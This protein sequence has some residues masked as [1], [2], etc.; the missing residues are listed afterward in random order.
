MGVNFNNDNNN[1][2]NRKEFENNLARKST[3]M[4]KNERDK[5]MSIF[6]A[7]AGDDKIF[8]ADEAKQVFAELQALDIDKNKSISKEELNN[9][10]NE[11]EL[12]KAMS[13][14]DDEKTRDS[15]FTRIIEFVKTLKTEEPTQKDTEKPNTATEK[16]AQHETIAEERGYKETAIS[17]DRKIFYDEQNK[18]YVRWSDKNKNFIKLNGMTDINE[19]GVMTFNGIRCRYND[20]GKLEKVNDANGQIGEFKQGGTGDC[21]L[22]SAV[23]ALNNNDAGKEMLKDIVKADGNGNVTVS[24]KG[25]NKTYTISADELDSKDFGEKSY[26]KGDRDVL[27]IEVAV[28]KFRTEILEMKNKGQ[29]VSQYS[30]FFSSAMNTEDVLDGGDPI[31]AIQ[32]LT[33]KS[34]SLVTSGADNFEEIKNKLPEFLTPQNPTSDNDTPTP[35]TIVSIGLKDTGGGGHAVTVLRMNDDTVTYL[36]TNISSSKPQTMNREEFFAK[37]GTITYSDLSS[38]VK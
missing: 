19:S 23:T 21:W 6:D 33:G 4:T 27:A 11:T 29:D 15:F 38:P 30:S 12:T 34:A 35:K 14:I 26:S 13:K 17:K 28:E 18:Q 36:D 25:A 3:W 5:A 2:I 9:A 16:K 22:L 20:K 8:S 7:V 24:L 1:S 31:E 37:I 32:L 10:K